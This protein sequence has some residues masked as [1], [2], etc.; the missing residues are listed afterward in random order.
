MQ[1]KHIVL[2]LTALLC[3]AASC[4]N[5]DEKVYSELVADNY[6]KTAPK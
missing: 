1:K 5:L 2:G 6:Y 3:G 4:T